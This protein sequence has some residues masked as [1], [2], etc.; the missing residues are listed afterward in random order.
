M[1]ESDAIATTFECQ[2]F[3][4]VRGGGRPGLKIRELSLSRPLSR[5]VGILNTTLQREHRV[6]DYWRGVAKSRELE[7]NKFLGGKEIHSVVPK[8]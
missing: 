4:T 7:I 2:R 8:P 5:H 1:Y 3:S 6:S